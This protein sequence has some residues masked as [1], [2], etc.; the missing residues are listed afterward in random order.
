MGTY[1]TV[2]I[3]DAKTLN[4]SEIRSNR[5]NELFKM[6]LRGVKLDKIYKRAY[7]MASKKVAEGY[8]EEVIRRCQK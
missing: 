5:I 1:F 2:A 3:G 6:A 4:S 8:V 7:E